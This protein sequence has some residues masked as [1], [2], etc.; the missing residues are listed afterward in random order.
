MVFIKKNER[1]IS[2]PVLLLSFFLYSSCSTSGVNSNASRNKTGWID[3]HTF[4]IMAIGKP[5][6]KLTSTRERKES[7]KRA[8]LMNAHFKILKK[9]KKLSNKST[10]KDVAA[11]AVRSKTAVK[12]TTIIKNGKV[13]SE[14]YDRNDNCEITYRVRNKN[15]NM[16]I[17]ESDLS[18]IDVIY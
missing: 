11:A 8:A 16:L 2:L 7:A 1:C 15:L 13:L 17:K 18:S 3:D 5:V 10:G 14:Q 6:R 12:I 4:V 9:F